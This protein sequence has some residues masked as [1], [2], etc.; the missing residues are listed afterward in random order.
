MDIL[1]KLTGKILQLMK[2]ILFHSCNR[3]ALRGSVTHLCFILPR[4]AAKYVH[5][6]RFLYKTHKVFFL[7]S[8]SQ[9]YPMLRSINEN[10]PMVRTNVNQ[11]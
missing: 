9:N 4:A 11:V 5:H 7:L 10:Y 3:Q 8:L 6:P 1:R 2:L